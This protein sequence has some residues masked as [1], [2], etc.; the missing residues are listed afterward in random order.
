MSARTCDELG[1]CQARADCADC[2]HRPTLPFRDD[3]DTPAELTHGERV[4]MGITWAA[5]V[6]CLGALLLAVART[7][8]GGV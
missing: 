2:P 3:D 1:V 6:A 4:V 7:C 5:W 8:G